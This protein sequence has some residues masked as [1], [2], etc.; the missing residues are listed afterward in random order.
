M[1][2][3]FQLLIH[4]LLHRYI[5]RFYRVSH[6]YMTLNVAETQP[7]PAY[8]E[9]LEVQ[10]VGDDHTQDLLSICQCIATIAR[11]VIER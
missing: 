7:I 8:Q 9:I 10:Q 4:G 6:P 11:D 1:H 3:V 5:Q 2:A